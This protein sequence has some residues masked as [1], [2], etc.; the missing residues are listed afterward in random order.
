MDRLITLEVH[1]PAA[2][3]NAFRLPAWNLPCAQLFAEHFAKVVGDADV[4]AVSPDSGASSAPSS[5]V[6]PWSSNWAARSAAP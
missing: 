3:D 2:F 6:R 1:N 5:F 4:V